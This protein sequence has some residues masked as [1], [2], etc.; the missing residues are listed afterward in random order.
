MPELR[1]IILLFIFS[2]FYSCEST[3]Y[4]VSQTYLFK[5]QEKQSDILIFLPGRESD[6]TDFDKKGLLLIIRGSGLPVDCV[7]ANAVFPFYMDRSLLVRLDGD[8]FGK[9]GL[10]EYRNYWFIGNS[11]GALGSL[12][13]VQSYPGKIKGIIMLGPY[14]GEGAVPRKIAEAGGLLKWESKI[15]PGSDYLEDTW[16][17]LKKCIYDKKGNYPVIIFLC[18]KSDRYHDTQDLLAR[19]LPEDCV[20]WSEGGH[21][22]TAW[23]TAFN[24]FI[25]SGKAKELFLNP[26]KPQRQ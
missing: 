22:W 25:K 16:A 7:S 26:V 17:Y 4:M 2:L 8:V 1:T 11:M 10:A 18:G 21:D 24:N 3:K 6:F 23:R 14:L 19:A 12:L 20:F 9:P 15:P 13:Y 5:P